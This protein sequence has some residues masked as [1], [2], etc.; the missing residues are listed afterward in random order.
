MEG[1]ICLFHNLSCHFTLHSISPRRLGLMRF[2]PAAEQCI[3]SQI[4]ISERWWEQNDTSSDVS[5]GV[6]ENTR[7]GTSEEAKLHEGSV[8]RNAPLDFSFSR[9]HPTQPKRGN[10]RR[11]K[12]TR[13]AT[14]AI[15]LRSDSNGGQYDHHLKRNT[16]ELYQNTPAVRKDVFGKT[17]ERCLVV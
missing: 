4:Q 14:R 12:I 7:N 6:R 9:F 16:R 2:A 11:V 5:D 3:C 10:R 15:C 13:L 1:A 17:L 8:L